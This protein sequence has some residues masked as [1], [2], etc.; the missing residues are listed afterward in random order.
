MHNSAT[1]LSGKVALITGSGRGMGRAHA[2]AMA[3]RGADVLVND[4]LEEEAR[5]TADAVRRCGRRAELALV[6]IT[7]AKA[8]QAMVT[9]AEGTLGPVDILV[10]NAGIGQHLA[11]EAITEGDFRRMFDVHV[12][13][14]FFVTQAVVPSMKTRRYGKII[15]IS[16]IWGMVGADTASHYCAAKAALL[17]FTK[18][19][20]KELAPWQI[21]VN[22]VAPGG[23]MTEMPIKVQGMEK[24]RAKEQRV[25]LKRWAAPEEISHAVVFLAS[26]EA[27]FIT[28]QVI[29]PNGGET[30]VGF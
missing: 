12:M 5:E 20:A 22:A 17:G 7:D 11:I 9:D 16:S 24:I 13:A 19:W 6:D 29:S 8:V 18:A 21:C 25:P 2:I 3:T 26:P 27:D 15:N 1:D 4:V 23:V 14:S 28:G 30:I 10:N